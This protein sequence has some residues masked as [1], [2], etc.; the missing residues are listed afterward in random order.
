MILGRSRAFVKDT[1]VVGIYSVDPEDN[2]ITYYIDWG[3][4]T[5]PGWSPFFQS[6]ETIARS[7][8]YVDTGIYFIRAKARDIDRAESGWS[9]TFR[10]IIEPDTAQSILSKKEEN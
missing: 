9:D 10:L 5:K 3:D 2:V 6:G 7:H 8:I 4:T 1:V